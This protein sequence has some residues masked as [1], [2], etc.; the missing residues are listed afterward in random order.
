MISNSIIGLRSVVR[1][2]SVV[3]ES[4]LMGASHFEPYPSVSERVPL[5][6]GRD[7]LIRRAIVD[8]NARIGDGCRLVNE[9]GVRNADAE[10]YCI[11]EGVIVVP[12][13]AELPPGTVI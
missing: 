8:V 13:G 5:G 7:C 11:R 12:R 3:E 4:V 10:G 9:G 2:G 6:I 1:A